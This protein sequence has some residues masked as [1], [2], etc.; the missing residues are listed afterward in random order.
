MKIGNAREVQ[1]FIKSFFPFFPLNMARQWVSFAFFAQ[2][3]SDKKTK[4]FA[5]GS[6]AWPSQRDGTYI[7]VL[8][9]DFQVSHFSYPSGS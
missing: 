3:S 7:D 4:D 2:L 5:E 6:F 1:V 8:Q 9:F